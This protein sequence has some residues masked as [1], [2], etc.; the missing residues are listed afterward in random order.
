MKSRT[1]LDINEFLLFGMFGSSCRRVEILSKSAGSLNNFG[2]L[3][4]TCVSL[5]FFFF[6]TRDPSVI[7]QQPRCD[8]SLT[9]VLSQSRRLSVDMLHVKHGLHGLNGSQTTGARRLAVC[10]CVV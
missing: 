3:L 5:D 1:A 2:V 7:N 4:Y 9:T 10:G 8:N 6:Q